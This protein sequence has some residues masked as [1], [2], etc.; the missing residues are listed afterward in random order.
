MR[1]SEW[2]KKQTLD[3]KGLL[4]TVQLGK[5]RGGGRYLSPSFVEVSQRYH[6]RGN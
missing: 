2:L 4:Q 3:G 6:A 5:G 1:R